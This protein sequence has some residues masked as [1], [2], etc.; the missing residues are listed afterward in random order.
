MSENQ[1]K[2]TPFSATNRKKAPSVEGEKT[3]SVTNKKSPSYYIQG[4]LLGIVGDKEMK[5]ILCSK[6]QKE[7]STK[8]RISGLLLILDY[9]ARK[10]KTTSMSSELSRQYVSTFKGAKNPQTIRQPLALLVHLGLIEIVQKAVIAPHRKA[11][12]KYCLNPSYGKPR[13]IK[14][15]ISLQQ[16]EKL[17]AA[18]ERQEKRLN[19]KHRTRKVIL[20]DLARLSLSPEGKNTALKMITSNEKSHGIQQFLKALEDTG[21]R[22]ISINPSGT[23]YHYAMKCPRELKPHLLLTEKPVANIDM[24]AAHLVCL[25]CVGRDRVTWMRKQGIDTANLEVEIDRYK[26]TLESVDIYEELGGKLN[27]KEFKRTLL[28]SLNMATTKA[29]KLPPYQK[30]KTKFP[31]IVRIIEDIKKND[32]KALSKQLQFFTAQIIES[33]LFEVQSLSIPCLPDTDALIAPSEFESQVRGILSDCI[34]KATG[35]ATT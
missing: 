3:P 4:S 12:A 19:K 10:N 25:L 26:T 13:S 14:A 21:S 28:T 24:K 35:S 6:N 5:D 18:P 17:K 31:R 32:H 27:R 7:W 8:K 30:L 16:E 11:S 33:A 29:N 20:E 15:E 22:T 9:F 34:K 2:K 23:I 1:S